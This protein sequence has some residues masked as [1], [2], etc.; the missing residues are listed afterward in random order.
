MVV[1]L[2]KKAATGAISAATAHGTL[3]ATVASTRPPG[4]VGTSARDRAKI[5]AF[6]AFRRVASTTIAVRCTKQSPQ[7]RF[8][9]TTEILLTEF[10]ETR[11]QRRSW[12]ALEAPLPVRTGYSAGAFLGA[13]FFAGA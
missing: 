4:A 1:S 12:D 13:A 6:R 8:V 5:G 9:H 2:R 10:A 3:E 11:N 7:L